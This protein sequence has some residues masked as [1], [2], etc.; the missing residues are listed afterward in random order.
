MAFTDHYVLPVAA[1]LADGT[2]WAN[3]F[4]LAGSRAHA[5]GNAGQRYNLKGD[6]GTITAG[7]WTPGTYQQP[8]VW[9]GC[10]NEPGDLDD[11]KRNADGTLNV[12]GMP[13][14]TLSTALQTYGASGG[15]GTVLQN[16]NYTADVNANMTTNVNDDGVTFINCRF[17]NTNTGNA[18]RIFSIDNYWLFINCDF[19]ANNSTATTITIGTWDTSCGFISCRFEASNPA[20]TQILSGNAAARIFNCV[21]IGNG[22]NTAYRQDTANSVVPAYVDNNTFYN[23]GTCWENGNTHTAGNNFFYN[24]LMVNCVTPVDFTDVS[25][26]SL[27]YFNNRVRNVTNPPSMGGTAEIISFNINTVDADDFVDTPNGNFNLLPT[28]PAVNA[29][30]DY[31]NI[32]AMDLI[33]SGGGFR[34]VNVRGGADQ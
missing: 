33:P 28:S 12:T 8:N 31:A 34:M 6:F 21:F 26:P 22:S 24:N 17:E 14:I 19:I 13:T 29:A 27:V 9:R 3:A 20:S 11:R 25:G 10:E 32:G 30:L 16:I 7:T 4:D 23:V 18:A 1:G 5:V 2:S 15:I